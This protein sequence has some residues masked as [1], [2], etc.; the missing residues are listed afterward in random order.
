MAQA[1]IKP[2]TFVEYL[3]YDDGSDIRYDLLSNGQ[4]IP[5]PNE[6]EENDYLAMVLFMKLSALINLRLIKPH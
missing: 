6:S 1:K 3:N 5:V 2:L 4:L